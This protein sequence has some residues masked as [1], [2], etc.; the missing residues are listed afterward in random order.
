MAR[1]PFTLAASVTSA[2]PQAGVVA[3]GALT[4]G[5]AGR[6]DSALV[7]LSDGR[8]VVARVPADADAASEILAET[9]ALR[10]LTAGV[11]ALLPF[12]PP[13]LRPRSS[14]LVVF[15]VTNDNK[16]K[17]FSFSSYFE[18]HAVSKSSFCRIS[19][20]KSETISGGCSVKRGHSHSQL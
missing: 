19:L 10:A 13:T 4:E 8:R 17:A 7:D 2:L 16:Q 12:R 9:R 1:S 18:D 15:T 6:Y 11:R 14:I 20:T 5:T 3:V